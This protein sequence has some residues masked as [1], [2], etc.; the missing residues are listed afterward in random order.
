MF[1]LDGYWVIAD[2]T[3]IPDLFSHGIVA[4]KARGRLPMKPWVKVAFITY[5]AI[6]FPLM[7]LFFGLLMWN[8][9]F[10]LN[11]VTEAAAVHAA[12]LA[13]AVTRADVATILVAS[14]GI[15]MA[16]ILMAAL[17]LLTGI[18]LLRASGLLQAWWRRGSLRHRMGAG[19]VAAGLVLLILTTWTRQLM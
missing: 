11:L 18:L 17:L 10:L 13:E 2:A 3:G 14:V 12:T 16:L 6:S 9:P 4:L 7:V 1:R 15:T 5:F 8:L 19:S